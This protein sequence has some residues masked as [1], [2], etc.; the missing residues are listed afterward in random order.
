MNFIS[1]CLKAF[2]ICK[3][4]QGVRKEKKM[5]RR[6][7]Y[8]ILSLWCHSTGKNKEILQYASE[9]KLHMQSYKIGGNT[10][11]HKKVKLIA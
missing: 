9:N 4:I 2:V 10:I 6:M 5:S 3:E 8:L 11:E 1:M 7:F